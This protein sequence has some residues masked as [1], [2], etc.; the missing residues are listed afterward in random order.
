MK[1][2]FFFSELALLTCVELIQAVR[3]LSTPLQPLSKEFVPLMTQIYNS[4]LSILAVQDVDQVFFH[5]FSF[6]LLFSS[7]LPFHFIFF[8]HIFLGSKRESN[9]VY[10]LCNCSFRRCFI[11]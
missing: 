8:L 9:L 6:L 2:F 11:C 10:W 7:F 3:P 4:T 5:F 1:I